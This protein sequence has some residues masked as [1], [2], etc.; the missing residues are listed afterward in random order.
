M[1]DADIPHRS[2]LD[3]HRDVRRRSLMFGR[4]IDELPDAGV[5]K[6]VDPRQ[7][8]RSGN[9]ARVLA[10]KQ[11]PWDQPVAVGVR[12]R[13]NIAGRVEDRAFDC[14]F[15]HYALACAQCPPGSCGE[16]R[17]E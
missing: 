14:G 5:E 3:Q 4:E 10:G 15:R 13:D 6:R 17:T 11:L 1:V 2:A 7:A 12:P 16:Q 8:I 9:G